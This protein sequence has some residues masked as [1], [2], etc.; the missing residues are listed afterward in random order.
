MKWLQGTLNKKVLILEI[1]VNMEYPSIIR[2]PFE[3]T[4][5]LNQKANFIRINESLPQ[6]TEELK[7]KGISINVNGIEW[8]FN[9]G[10]DA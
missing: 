3:K 9:F 6:L 7:D 5:Y 2:W 8:L 4:A 10:K 1:G